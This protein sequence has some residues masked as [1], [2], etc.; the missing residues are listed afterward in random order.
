[1]SY[2]LWAL[3]GDHPILSFFLLYVLLDGINTIVR[4]LRS[5]PCWNDCCKQDEEQP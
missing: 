5:A 1:M 2:S 3:I 4:T